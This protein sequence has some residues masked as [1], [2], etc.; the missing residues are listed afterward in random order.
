MFLEISNAY[1]TVKKQ[2]SWK[3]QQILEFSQLFVV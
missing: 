2:K 1:Y 3:L